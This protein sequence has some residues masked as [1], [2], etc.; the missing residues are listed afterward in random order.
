MVRELD[1]NTSLRDAEFKDESPVKTVEKIK[2]ILKAN[3]I[4]TKER[5]NESG[6]PYCHSVRVSVVG[7]T[8]GTNGKGLT[9]EFALASGYGELI[10]RLQSGFVSSISIQKEVAF[11]LRDNLATLMSV[12]E[13]MEMGGH[14]FR[15]ISDNLYTFTGLREEPRTILGRCADADGNL[16]VVPYHNITKD[17]KAYFPKGLSP[18]YTT[19]GTAAGN[20]MEEAIVQA[21]SEVMERSWQLRIFREG[22]SLPEVPDE[23]L[24]KY[25]AAYRIITYVRSKGFRVVIKDASLGTKFP[26]VCAVFVNERT[27][28]YHTHFGAYPIFEIALERAL[29]ETFQGRSLDDVASIEA[30]HY[31]RSDARSIDGISKE[32]VDGSAMKMVDFFVGK[33]DYAFDENI[34]FAG[35]NNKELLIECI[36][37]FRDMGLEVLFRDRS[38]LGFPTCQVIIPGFSEALIYR[39]SSDIDDNLYLPCAR[40]VLRNPAASTEE[41][42]R[43]LVKFLELS[44]KYGRTMEG[45]RTFSRHAALPVELPTAMD[46]WLLYASLSYAYYAMDM[47]EEAV[48]YID[49]MLRVRNGKNTEYLVAVKRCIMLK[50]NGYTQEQIKDSIAFFHSEK[51]CETLFE[52]MDA[53]KNPMEMFTL[54]CDETCTQECM[55]YGVCGLK[56]AEALI[57]LISKKWNSMDYEASVQSIRNLL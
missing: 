55:L 43:G 19:N 57:K 47:Y 49:A 50:K 48:R 18:I 46:A 53:G 52:C 25:E 2:E 17:C 7:T 30:F 6:V 35:K 32:M 13:Q 51:T 14:W 20:T 44:R 45:P 24:K 8:F 15:A 26:V 11:E 54:H 29:T 37:F 31:N 12:D 38:V 40:R 34:G 56:P 5:W 22:I 28:K 42:R 10:E 33:P 1:I 4:E 27:G 21:I 36:D 16:K 41:D 23:V 9:K 39:L 3:G